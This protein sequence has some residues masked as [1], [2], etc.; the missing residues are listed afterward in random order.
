M[1]SDSTK[2]RRRIWSVVVALLVG[3]ALW[4]LIPNYRLD[5]DCM[6]PAL[7]DGER[8]WFNRFS[9]LWAGPQ[10]G[11]VVVF[12]LEGKKWVSRIVAT[13]GE[14]VRL[15]LQ[16]VL[17]NNRV[18]EDGV[19]RNWQSWDQH[20][21]IGVAEPVRIPPSHVYVL[22]DNLR[23]EHDDSRVFGPIPVASIESKKAW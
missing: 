15:Q 9:Y 17:I 5:G 2:R 6:A 20:G 10:A 8:H 23:A 22:S 21:Q 13:E 11:D 7:N 18:R 4:I 1:N 14:T 3:M 12:R 19:L 16:Q